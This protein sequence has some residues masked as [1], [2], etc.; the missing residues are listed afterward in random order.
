MVQQKLLDAAKN[1][2]T[3]IQLKPDK[4]SEILLKYLLFLRSLK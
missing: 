3:N 2:V 4:S 1:H